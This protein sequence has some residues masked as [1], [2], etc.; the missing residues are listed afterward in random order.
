M[1]SLWWKLWLFKFQEIPEKYPCFRVIF[2][3]NWINPLVALH[4]I[5]LLIC[6][7][8]LLKIVHQH[9]K[10]GTRRNENSLQ[11]ATNFVQF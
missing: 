4:L 6:S 2:R 11:I 8:L 1:W 3:R 9:M 5:S 7:T 10:F